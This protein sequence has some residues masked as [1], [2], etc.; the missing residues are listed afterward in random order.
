MIDLPS[1]TR[2]DVAAQLWRWLPGVYRARDADGR[3][4]AFLALFADELWRLRRLAEQQHADHFIDSAQ[5]WAVAYL[6][7]L[8][9]TSVLFTGD[10]GQ[11]REI[12]MRNR[13]DVKNTLHWRRQK[14]TLAGLEGVARDVGG[15]GV[16]AVEM[17]ERTAWLQNLVHVKP[18][19]VFALDLRHG[20]AVAAAATPFSRARALADLRPPGQR[21][22]W[23]QVGHVLAFQWP[24]ASHP[25]SGVVP[26]ALGGGRF[27]F[28]PLGLDTALHAG[29]ATDALRTQVAARPGATGADI[30][31]P[32]ADDTPVRLRDLRAHPAAYV[33]SPLGFS[34]RED[35]IALVGGAPAASPA[36]EPALDF[37]DL[38]DARGLL[39][40]DTTAYPAG[41]R[42]ELAALRLGAVLQPVGSALAPV[43]YSPG[44]PW[45]SQLQLRNPSGRLALDTVAPDFGYT[46]GMVPYQPDAGEFHHPVLLLRVANQGGAA[47]AFPASEA[48]V[49]NARGQALQVVLPALP[50]VA[51]GAA[52]H[53]YV[54]ADGSTYFARGDHGAG[55]PDRNPDSS[56]FGAY[57]AP[58]LARAGEGQRR[59]RPGHPPGAA[60]WRRVVARSLCCWDQPLVPP[61]APGEVAIDP[62]RG[63]LAFPAGEVPV[64]ALSVDFRFGRTAPLGAGPFAR[65]G[66]PAATLTVARTRD[67]GFASLQA[68]IAAAPQGR[69]EPV[70]IEILD[71]AV[72][73][74]VLLIENRSF[75]GG[76]VLQAAAQQTPFVVRPAAAPQLLRVANSTLGRL[77]LDGLCWAGGALQVNGAVA[78][79]ALRHCTMQP[80]DTALQVA[81]AG[82][83]ALSLDHCISGPIV[84][85]TGTCTLDDCIVQHPAAT[86][87][88]PG[89]ATAIAAGSSALALARC[90]V[91]GSVAAAGA[92]VSSTLCYGDFTLAAAGAACLRF[93]R[94]PRSLAVPAFRCTSATPIFVSLRWGDAGY[95]HL[96]PNTAR[97]LTHGG[98]EGGEIGAFHAAGLPWRTQNAG[99]RLAESI[100]AGLVPV[101]I[102][103]L[104]GPRFPGRALP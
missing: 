65:A 8:V 38:A 16:H 96:H 70:V 33:D 85:G 55:V 12:A 51:P 29:G 104:P 23:H 102:R 30:C 82:A 21:T 20:E 42:F 97:S 75:P 41:L 90:T 27:C 61:L 25:L 17:F 39:S 74:E 73:E 47:A 15:F 89:A 32:N 45:A 87:E 79:L 24:I 66:L 19:A 103:V 31:R 92:T 93:S 37:G 98:E 57:A 68:A 59:I 22:G 9:G 53:F 84:L 101:Q 77:A 6:A 83:C 67:A 95:A 18:A 4:Q 1:P 100:P 69:L 72:Y 5:D 34:I 3:L 13:D 58:H 46:P 71:S 64:G 11:R 76:L 49:R 44:Q 7:D 28:H 48:I 52:Y 99:L 60:R 35:G 56:L 86:V 81:T 10:A 88:Q 62:E 40:T 14:G 26:R 54:A 50:A 78:A 94:L 63:R 43:P 80:E 91:I 2:A 36:L